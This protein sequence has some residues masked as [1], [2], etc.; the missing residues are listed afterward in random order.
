MGHIIPRKK[1]SENYDCKFLNVEVALFGLLYLSSTLFG[2]KTNMWLAEM[3][4]YKDSEGLENNISPT[5][6]VIKI[7]SWDIN[8]TLSKKEIPNK[9]AN[10]GN[11]HMSL[12]ILHLKFTLWNYLDIT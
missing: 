9:A 1:Y 8:T 6:I 7:I 12:L 11:I 3:T 4:V 10:Y 2:R 5:Y